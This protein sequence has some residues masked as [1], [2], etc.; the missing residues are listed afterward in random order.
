M[1]KLGTFVVAGIFGIACVANASESKQ[2]SGNEANSGK[3]ESTLESYINKGFGPQSPRDLKMKNGKNPDQFTKAPSTSSMNLC[4][5]HFHKNAEHK[6]GEFTKPASSDD[7]HGH[8]A[9]F[10]YSGKLSAKEATPLEKPVCVGEH[11]G[12]NAG[13]TVELHYVHSTASVTPGAT[14]GACLHENNANP[15]LRV[16][17]QVLV[18][19]NDEKA[20]DFRQ[21]AQTT[22]KSGFHQAVNMPKNTGPSI[23]YTG[24]TTG[25]AYN[26][27]PSPIRVTWGVNSKV[28]KV[29]ANSV[30]EWCK[31][32]SFNENHAHGSRNLV[33]TPELLSRIK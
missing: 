5:I 13:D 3:T 2:P 9:G 1:N 10:V 21:L 33:T 24:S 6:G 18:L 16:Q 25:P 11:G 19:V 17:A 32:N 8:N 22:Q 14:L 29:N 30:G 26:Q 27:K 28:L 4:N 31:A 23:E 15:E 7:G 20:K 12:L